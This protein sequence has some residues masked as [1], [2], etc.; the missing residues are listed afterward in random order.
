MKLAFFSKKV[1]LAAKPVC[2]SCKL[3]DDDLINF[4]QICNNK[5][6]T[7]INRGLAT[8][9]SIFFSYT[10]GTFDST[11]VVKLLFYNYEGKKDLKNVKR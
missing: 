1:P 2:D 10:R 9:K 4:S 5:L 6:V 8:I 3:F 11:F 7:Y